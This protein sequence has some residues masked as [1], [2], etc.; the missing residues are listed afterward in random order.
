MYS[1]VAMARTGSSSPEHRSAALIIKQQL[2]HLYDKWRYFTEGKPPQKTQKLYHMDWCRTTGLTTGTDILRPITNTSAAWGK[3]KTGSQSWL[4]HL[5]GPALEG[6]TR[7]NSPEN[8]WA[9]WS[10]QK[11]GEV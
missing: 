9:L 7:H 11:K 8:F 5:R 10:L 2:Y 4:L 1:P 3:K 6:N